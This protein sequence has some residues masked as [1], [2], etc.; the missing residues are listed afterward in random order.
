MQRQRFVHQDMDVFLHFAFSSSVAVRRTIRPTPSKYSLTLEVLFDAGVLVFDV[1]RRRDALGDHAG[2]KP[3]R[4]VL[5]ATA[6]EDQL[7][8]IRSAQVDVL[9]DDLCPKRWPSGQS[10]A[11]RPPLE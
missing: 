4:G 1:Q 9:S 8:P 11:R 5:L 2:A 7:H 6:W 3:P 10:P